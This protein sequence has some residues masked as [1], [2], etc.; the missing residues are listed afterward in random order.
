MAEPIR[1]A[2]IAVRIACG[3]RSQIVKMEGLNAGLLCLA[4][5]PLPLTLKAVEGIGPA[6]AIADQELTQLRTLA[7][8]ALRR[9]TQFLAPFNQLQRARLAA[10]EK[11]A[12]IC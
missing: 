1:C 3:F 12:V 5:D 7:Q 8:N 9:Q 2:L 6:L 4:H 10:L 11:Y